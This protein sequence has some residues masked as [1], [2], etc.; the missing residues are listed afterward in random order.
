MYV[1]QPRLLLCPFVVI[2]WDELNAPI[3]L[4]VVSARYYMQVRVSET[5]IP[6]NKDGRSS[7]SEPL[8]YMR[9]D[10]NNKHVH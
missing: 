9:V 5:S 4:V 8:Y 3:L 2:L 1:Y 10:E 7:A 6:I